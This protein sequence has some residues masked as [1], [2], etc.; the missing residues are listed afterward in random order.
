MLRAQRLLALTRPLA[1]GHGH[2]AA[3]TL[4]TL[5]REKR[6]RKDTVA[7]RHPQKLLPLMTQSQ[8]SYSSPP[9]PETSAPPTKYF[10]AKSGAI[11][12]IMGTLGGMVGIGGGVVAIPLMVSFLGLTQHQS[13]GTSLV[14]VTGGAIVGATN[15]YLYGDGAIDFVAAGVIAP[16]AALFAPLGVRYVGISG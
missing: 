4:T 2:L 16:T 14:A 9:P 15:Y 10:I 6:I 1:Q 11:G 13:H 7:T 12:L 5:P 8:R 3:R